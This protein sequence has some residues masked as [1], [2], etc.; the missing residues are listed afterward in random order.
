MRFRNIFALILLFIPF[1]SSGQS[2]FI[3]SPSGLKYKFFTHETGTKPKKGDI[4]KFNFYLFTEK[5]SILFPKQKPLFP[6]QALVN[7]SYYKGD[8][9]EAF[10]M[11]SKGDSAM[12]LVSA[13]SF[14][15]G[16]DM[17]VP[18]GTMLKA[19]I[20]MVDIV[21]P[22]EQAQER[23]KEKDEAIAQEQ[24]LKTQETK[25]LERFINSQE[26][27]AIKTDEGL[28]YLIDH[29]GTGPLPKDSQT[30]I[31]KYTGH[32]LDGVVAEEENNKVIS[33]VLG[34]HEVIKGLEMGARLLNKHARA[35]LFIPSWLG[36][37]DKG[38]GK[39]IQPHMPAIYDIEILEIK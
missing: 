5:D 25:G 7:S 37:G 21:T 4:V 30:V 31:I 12:F 23:Q 17:P 11:M 34:R 20:K 1:L 3:T 24:R 14:Y 35:R 29:K 8:I 36:Y 6:Q 16:Q 2:S 32:S 26:P 9:E 18:K 13:D 22:E 38:K 19:T 39:V 27:K 10:V 28:Y 33:I 15:S